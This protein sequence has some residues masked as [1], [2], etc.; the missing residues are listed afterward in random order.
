MCKLAIQLQKFVPPWY[1]YNI[2]IIFNF[3]NFYNNIISTLILIRIFYFYDI[4]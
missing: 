1:S 2:F 4:Q 3:K